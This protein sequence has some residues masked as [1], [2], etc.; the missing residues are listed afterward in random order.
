M[1]QSQLKK[2][3][4]ND[5]RTKNPIAKIL[6]FFKPQTYQ[7]KKAYTRK[8]RAAARETILTRRGDW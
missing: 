5:K 7:S 3:F 8:G 2:L 6:R 4:S 1:A